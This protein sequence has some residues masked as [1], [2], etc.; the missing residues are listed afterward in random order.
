M[1]TVIMWVLLLNII[2]WLFV[3]IYFWLFD[4]YL[5]STPAADRSASFISESF[6]TALWHIVE[7]AACPCGYV[8]ACKLLKKLLIFNNHDLVFHA[9]INPPSAS[10]RSSSSISVRGSGPIRH[11][12]SDGNRRP[13][14]V[15]HLWCSF[16]QPKRSHGCHCRLWPEIK[17]IST[18]KLQ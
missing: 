4:D 3:L 15:S 13:D 14:S 17:K 1:I 5:I 6:C 10:P 7:M 8:A 16:G 2:W 12:I 18:K 11:A 9:S